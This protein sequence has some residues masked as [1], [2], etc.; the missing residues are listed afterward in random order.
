MPSAVVFRFSDFASDNM[1]RT[2]AP[3]SLSCSMGVTKLRSIFN[4]SMGGLCKLARL[5]KPVPTLYIATEASS[6]LRAAITRHPLS[7]PPLIAL[8]VRITVRDLHSYPGTTQ[9]PPHTIGQP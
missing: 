3:L 1:A 2:M 6:P 4:M 8:S 9:H 7:E 5:E